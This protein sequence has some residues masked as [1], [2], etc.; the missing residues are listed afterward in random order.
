MFDE[1]ALFRKEQ[2]TKQRVSMAANTLSTHLLD[3][4]H[5]QEV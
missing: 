4:R 2:P 3:G 5:E 1:F